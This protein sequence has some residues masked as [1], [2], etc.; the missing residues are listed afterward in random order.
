MYVIRAPS[1]P[2]HPYLSF[3]LRIQTVLSKAGLCAL[4]GWIPCILYVCASLVLSRMSK[5]T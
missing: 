5:E 4:V 2:L 1:L 3:A